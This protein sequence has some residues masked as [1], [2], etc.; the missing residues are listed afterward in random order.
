MVKNRTP[1]L[2]NDSNETVTKANVNTTVSSYETV[3]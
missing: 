2:L 1:P 3:I